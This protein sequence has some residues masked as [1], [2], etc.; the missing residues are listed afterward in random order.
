ME[1][2][3]NENDVNMGICCK[4][5]PWGFQFSNSRHSKNLNNEND[6]FSVSNFSDFLLNCSSSIKI[7]QYSNFL[8]TN[9]IER[10][11]HFSKVSVSWFSGGL[12]W[13]FIKSKESHQ[14][15]TCTCTNCSLRHPQFGIFGSIDLWINLGFSGTIFPTVPSYGHYLLNCCDDFP[16]KLNFQAE[17]KNAWHSSCRCH[18]AASSPKLGHTMTKPWW[19]PFLY[20]CFNVASLYTHNG[21]SILT[22]FRYISLFQPISRHPGTFYIGCC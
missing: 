19:P 5:P 8:P 9:K 10:Q 4:Q 14:A 20:Q 18:C 7:M 16:Y 6:F 3:K 22:Y 1:N 12:D 2:R 17:F 15:A 21:L 11:Q 13:C